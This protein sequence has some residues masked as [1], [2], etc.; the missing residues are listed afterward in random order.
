MFRACQIPHVVAIAAIRTIFFH[1]L[2][3]VLCWITLRTSFRFVAAVGKGI[4]IQTKICHQT[5]WAIKRFT[6]TWSGSST[7]I[8]HPSQTSPGT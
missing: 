6:K 8:P 3:P 7:S 1:F 4:L 5:S 2:E